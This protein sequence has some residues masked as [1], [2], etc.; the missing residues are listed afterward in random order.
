[1]PLT[2][3]LDGNP[4]IVQNVVDIGAYELQSVV[5]LMVEIQTPLTNIAPY[6]ALG[7]VGTV[8]GGRPAVL[9]WDFGDGTGITNQLAVSHA[10]AV[11][12]AYTVTL[13][14]SNDFTPGGT[15]TSM[16]VVVPPFLSS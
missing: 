14:A 9:S 3:D 16:T 13:T 4:R 8:G 2:T 6:Y 5:P 7:F 12:G 15:T 10:W 1:M 11:P